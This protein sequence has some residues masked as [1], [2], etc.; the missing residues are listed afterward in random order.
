MN[1]N[2]Y[3]RLDRF[4]GVPLCALLSLI[5]RFRRTSALT[6]SPR[7]ILVIL[8]SETGS[9]VIASRMLEQLTRRY[10]N[11]SLYLLVSARSRGVLDV[12]KVVPDNNILTLNDSSLSAFA[13]DTWRVLRVLRRSTIDIA[14]DCEL[15]ARISSVFSYL[16]GAQ[17]RVGFHRHTQEGLYRGSFINRPVLYNPYR[18]MSEQFLT[19]VD[20]IDSSSVPLVKKTSFSE[21][22][23][24]PAILPQENIRV[25]VAKLHADFPAIE[26]KHLVLVY[27]GG[28]VLPLRA[29]PLGYYCQ[30]CASLLAD[31]YAVGIIGLEGDKALG[32]LI[33]AF[34]KN[35]CC[36]D[37]TGYTN[38]LQD[39]LALYQRA[40][41]VVAN[42]GGPA[43]LATLTSTPTL[44]LFGPETPTLYKP[45]GVNV[46]CL[47]RPIPCSPCLTAFN[48]R[49]SPCDGDN[50]CLK[51]ITPDQVLAKTREILSLRRAGPEM[52]QQSRMTS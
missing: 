24:K 19:M 12:L 11:A 23:T 25:V 51:R 42:D 41:L 35:Q 9:L 6:A 14:I 33:T 4:L 18:H 31:G 27:P 29:W 20:A 13:A 34:C 39:L 30:L 38:S 7:A 50:Q 10:P 36:I 26:R 46:H 40:A 22:T 21:F 43:Q 8:L 37:L 47:Y 48:H 3:R 32:S 16:S 45:L 49:K 15:F 44:V 28:G 52:V 5:D 1:I 2:I 17:L